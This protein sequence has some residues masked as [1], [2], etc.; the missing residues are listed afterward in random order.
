MDDMSPPPVRLLIHGA[1]GRMGRALLRLAAEDNRF[2]VVAACSASGNALTEAGEVPLFAASALD[3]VP[4]FD[5]AVDFSLPPGFDR[6]LALCRQ[7]EVALVS[8]TTGLEA[9]Q[10]TALEQAALQVP[11]L[12]AANFS[13]GVAVLGDL[14]RRA[15]QALPQW[16]CD[17]IE[18]HHI[19]KRDAPSGYSAGTGRGGPAGTRRRTALC[20]PARRRH[21]G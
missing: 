15:A 7:R 16:D 17:L 3:Q 12:W 4:A 21:R 14:V 5:V 9:A 11:V 8:G 10:F 19:H 20:Q 6:I 1:S 13:L 2:R 18:A